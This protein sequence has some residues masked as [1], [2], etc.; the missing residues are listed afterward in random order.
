[1]VAIVEVLSELY[2]RTCLLYCFFIPCIS[3]FSFHVNDLSGLL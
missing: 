2:V 1:M 3:V